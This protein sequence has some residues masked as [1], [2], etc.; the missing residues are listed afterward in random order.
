MRA[1]LLVR[2]I[3]DE[4]LA[5]QDDETPINGIRETEGGI[6]LYAYATP[7]YLSQ[8]GEADLRKCFAGL[9]VEITS[10]RSNGRLI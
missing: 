3:F 8:V 6:L 7:R 2:I 9:A 10:Q 4:V 1:I 5:G